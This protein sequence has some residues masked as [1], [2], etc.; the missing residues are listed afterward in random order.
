MER[1]EGS[2][3]LPNR[4]LYIP[5]QLRLREYMGNWKAHLQWSIDSGL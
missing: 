3:A 2:V 1:K 5:I 4:W